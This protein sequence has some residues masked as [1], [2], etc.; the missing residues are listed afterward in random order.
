MWYILIAV[1]TLLGPPT[2]KTFYARMTVNETYDPGYSN[3][4]SPEFQT[5]ATTFN[6]KLGEF[7][8]KKLFGFERIEVKELANGSVIVDF[9]IVVQNSLN[10][11][12][13]IIV[14][15]LN[16]GNGGT[17]GY[18]FLG[19]FSINTTDQQSASSTQSPTATV[20]GLSRVQ[21][22]FTAILTF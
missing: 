18:T 4:S 7:L 15:A 5:F 11:T 16:D 21:F 8:S 1:I 22:G 19:N 13:D 12:V 9:D 3:S 14:Q 20:T 6:Q 2:T 10:A 17:L